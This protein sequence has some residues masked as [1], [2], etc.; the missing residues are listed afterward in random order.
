MVTNAE[1]T[2]VSW[3]PRCNLTET[4]RKSLSQIVH[5]L[6][7][8]ASQITR[9]QNHFENLIAII[10]VMLMAAWVFGD[11]GAGCALLPWCP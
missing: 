1:V 8:T 5:S 11:S 6:Q 4:L 7:P 10:A 3:R 9:H 2:Q